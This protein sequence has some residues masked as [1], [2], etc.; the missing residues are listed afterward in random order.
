[1]DKIPS[2]G[3]LLPDFL[4]KTGIHRARRTDDLAEKWAAVAGEFRRHTVLGGVRR[5]VLEIIVSDTIYVQEMTFRK[6][7]F[8]EKMREAYPAA[9]FKDI[10]FRVGEVEKIDN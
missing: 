2:L 4:A 6:A 1:M 5:G 7:E 9:K 8:L 10:R 3:D